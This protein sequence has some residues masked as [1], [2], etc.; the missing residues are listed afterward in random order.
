MRNGTVW[1]GVGGM[2]EWKWEPGRGEHGQELGSV[3]MADA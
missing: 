2:T 3:A 1:V